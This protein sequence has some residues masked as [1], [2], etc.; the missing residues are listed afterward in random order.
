ML[1]APCD[2]YLIAKKMLYELNKLQCMKHR[3]EQCPNRPAALGTMRNE[4]V[5]LDDIDYPNYLGGHL[6]SDDPG[7]HVHIASN[8]L[9]A[10][11]PQ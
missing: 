5:V 4:H 11:C 2:A 1:P 3:K 8:P 10:Y 9:I 7:I 6:T